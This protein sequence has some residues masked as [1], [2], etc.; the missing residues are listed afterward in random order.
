MR[1]SRRGSPIEQFE[2]GELE[3]SRT[4]REERERVREREGAEGG[5]TGERRE[6]VMGGKRTIPGRGSVGAR[7]RGRRVRRKGRERSEKAEVWAMGR[8]QR[9]RDERER[10]RMERVAQIRGS[11]GER[12]YEELKVRMERVRRRNRMGRIPGT[13]NVTAQRVVTGARAR[14]V[15]RTKRRIG[16]RGGKEARRERRRPDGTP[17][18]RVPVMVGLEVRGFGITAVSLAVRLFANR[19]SGHILIKVVAGFGWGRT[20]GN[21][22][23]GAGRARGVRRLRGLETGVAFVQAYVFILLTCLYRKDMVVGGH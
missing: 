21:P 4:K 1:E 9:A 18:G 19:M 5:R 22:R 12:R 2:R 13:Y 3:V 7:G 16:R 11:R 15:W 8:E 20:R 17:N 10:R 14:T 6:R 23:G